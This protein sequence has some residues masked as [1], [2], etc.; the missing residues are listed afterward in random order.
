MNIFVFGSNLSGIHGAGAAKI[1][2]QKHGARWGLGI[3]RSGSSYAIPTKGYRLIPISLAQVASYI[4]DFKYYAFTRPEHTFQ[5]TCIGC[6][7]AGFTN[8][9][10]APLFADAP[11]NCFFD[12][13]WKP[14]LGEDK[15]YWGTY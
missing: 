5:V 8:E 9:E 1:A 6:G 11:K 13:E 4:N 3:G 10:I 12:T 7:L 14:I 15:N 2:F